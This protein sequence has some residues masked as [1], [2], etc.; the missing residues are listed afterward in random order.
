MTV[1]VE[2]RTAPRNILF[3]VMP[4]NQLYFLNLNLTGSKEKPVNPNHRLRRGTA[5]IPRK[6]R[7]ALLFVKLFVKY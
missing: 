5:R 7:C 4:L 1:C 3:M 6:S 2:D